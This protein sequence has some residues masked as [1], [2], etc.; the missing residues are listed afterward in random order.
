MITYLINF[1]ICSAVLMLVYHL[2][3]K[4]KSM[5]TFNRIY[6]LLSILFSLA[7]PFIAVKQSST[8][9]PY[10]KPVPE[11]ILSAVPITNESPVNPPFATA[12]H[13]TVNYIPSILLAVYGLIALLLLSRF[14]RNLYLIRATIRNNE[15]I[16]YKNAQLILVEQRSTPHTFLS[17]IFLNKDDYNSK[18]IENE[19]LQH[20]L[21]HARERHSV[22]VIFMELVQVFCWFNPCLIFYRKAIQLNHE[23]IADAAVLRSN[24]DVSGYQSLLFSKIGQ[25]KSLDMTSQFNFSITK[26]RFTMMTK[27][28]S[29]FTAWAARLAIIPVMAIAFIVFCNKT[30]AQQ[31]PPA[32]QTVKLKQEKAIEAVAQTA[33]LKQ[34]K[35]RSLLPPPPPPLMSNGYPSTKNGIPEGQMKE[36]K[37]IVSKYLPDGPTTT[38]N[39]KKTVLTKE[40]NIR[41]QFLYSN[42]SHKQQQMQMLGFRYPFSPLPSCKPTNKQLDQ[43]KNA[44]VYGVWIDDKRIKNTELVNHQPDDFGQVFVSSLTKR[45][46]ENDKFRVQVN[47]MTKD[48]YEKYRKD[49]EAKRHTPEMYSYRYMPRKKD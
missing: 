39:Y 38:A 35:D 28:T 1:T 46:N 12:Q 47:L 48:F 4:N 2:L 30:E 21:A 45:A 44:K 3:L 22:D 42:M 33:N 29:V 40:D 11:Q 31:T 23:F 13:D 19:V 41:L 24:N 10:I 43:W 17:Y 36:Y 8:P 15:N 25:L 20:E 49:A 16:T 14:A 37:T 18:H 26:T 34:E 5:Y 27:T 32:T 9:L 6:L 7:V